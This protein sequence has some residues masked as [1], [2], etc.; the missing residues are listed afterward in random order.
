MRLQSMICISKQNGFL[1][2]QTM[3]AHVCSPVLWSVLISCYS[4]TIMVSFFLLEKLSRL[5]QKSIFM[6]ADL[7]YLNRSVLQIFNV[8]RYNLSKINEIISI[9]CSMSALTFF[10]EILAPPSKIQ[11]YGCWLILF[12]SVSTSVCHPKV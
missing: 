12:K 9:P 11:L 6:A 3:K 7:F 4:Y 10:W 5:H 2:K 1:N 8:S